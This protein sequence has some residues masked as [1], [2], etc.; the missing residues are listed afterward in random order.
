M[1]KILFLI[2]FGGLFMSNNLNAQVISNEEVNDA[3]LLNAKKIILQLQ[4]EIQDLM[5]DLN[6][7]G[8]KSLRIVALLFMVILK[9]KQEKKYCTII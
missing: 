6:P 2:L 7:I 4:D 9:L 8:L 3:K 1:K 5:K